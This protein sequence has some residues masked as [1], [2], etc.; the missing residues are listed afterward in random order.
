[1]RRNVYTKIEIQHEKYEFPHF[2]SVCIQYVPVVSAL[3]SLYEY[4]VLFCVREWECSLVCHFSIFSYL[5]VLI[6]LLLV[7][8]WNITRFKVSIYLNEHRFMLHKQA[9][10]YFINSSKNDNI[11][12]G[13]HRAPLNDMLKFKIVPMHSGGIFLKINSKRIVCSP[14]QVISINPHSRS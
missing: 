10:T 1:M 8:F 12:R 6:A 13:K 4:T 7:S 9:Q 3:I 2:V 11:L 5:S 14:N